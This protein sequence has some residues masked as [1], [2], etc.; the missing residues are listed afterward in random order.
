MI[1]ISELQS[2][3]T[4]PTH[5]QQQ[6]H[7]TILSPHL[8]LPTVQAIAKA[9]RDLD[10]D[11]YQTY[12]PYLSTSVSHTGFL[13][14]TSKGE[15]APATMRAGDQQLA[16][17]FLQSSVSLLQD[18]QL[19]DRQ[20]LPLHQKN[21]TERDCS[22]TRAF[23]HQLHTPSAVPMSHSSWQM[24]FNV[25]KCEVIHFGCKNRK[26]DYYLN[27]GRLGKG[28]VQ[29]DLGVI[30][31]QSLE[32]GM[33][34]QQAVKKANGMLAFIAK[35][36]EY[37]SREF[38][39]QLYKALVRPHLEYCVQF[40]SPNLRKDI[41]ATEGVQR[42]FTRL[43]PG[44]LIDFL[45]AGLSYDERLD[46]LGLYSL[47]FSRLR[48]YLIETYKILKG[49]NRLDAGRLFL[50][51]GKSRMRGHSLRIKGKPFRTEM[52]KNFFTQREVNLWN[53]LPQETV[54]ASSLAIFKKKLDMAFVAKGIKGYGEKAGTG[55]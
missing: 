43:I 4:P 26:T 45:T 25:D 12:S 44:N 2:L 39:L 36:F 49:L 11:I 55:F 40:W 42:R 33:Q 31:H 13:S 19:G 18:H 22:N 34:V 3:P 41:L 16:V 10:L 8:Y 20:A 5:K 54:E 35:G 15:I 1:V 6:K 46:R 32:V 28:E 52:R 21:E 29:R 27:G 7:R 14:L 48:G 38:L 30:V 53:S 51:L 23:F 24:Q 37:R 17:P 50:M 47:E 9:P